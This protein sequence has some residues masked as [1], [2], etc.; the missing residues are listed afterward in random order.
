[1]RFAIARR[2][3]DGIGHT[4]WPDSNR[5]VPALGAGSSVIAR[6]PLKIC[7]PAAVNS[8][9]NTVEPPRDIQGAGDPLRYRE[10]P[11]SQGKRDECSRHNSHRRAH[12]QQW[13]RCWRRE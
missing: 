13:L 5:M 10:R 6:C 7:T 8:R 2:P 11:F 1:M 12:L 3:Y 9:G 4:D